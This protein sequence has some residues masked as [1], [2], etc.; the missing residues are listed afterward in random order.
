MEFP[1]NKLEF[2][3]GILYKIYSNAQA[4]HF[5]LFPGGI[6]IAVSIKQSK[7]GNRFFLGWEKPLDVFD[8]KKIGMFFGKRVK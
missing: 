7:G 4:C 3:V 5:N 1:I 6:A 8:Q 2:V